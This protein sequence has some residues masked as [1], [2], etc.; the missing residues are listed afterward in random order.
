MKKLFT[1]ALL[2]AASV[3]YSQELTWGPNEFLQEVKQTPPITS[4]IVNTAYGNQGLYNIPSSTPVYVHIGVITN[5]STTATDWQ[6]VPE[7]CVWGT[8]SIEALCSSLGNNEWEYTISGS[9]ENF[10]HVDTADGEY[11]Q[12]IAIL[13]RS[14]T[15]DS[16]Q[17]NADGSDMYIPVYGDSLYSRIDVPIEQPE[18]VPIP[19]PIKATL[20]SVIPIVARASETASTDTLRVYFNGT[21]L[22]TVSGASAAKDSTSA[23]ITAYG[24]QQIVSRASNGVYANSDTVNFY[25]AEPTII[26]PLPPLTG[27]TDG[28]HYYTSPDSVTLVL[29]APYKNHIVVVGD[30]TNWIATPEYQ[31]YETPDLTRY[32]ITI[33]GLASGTQ[34]AYQYLIDDTIQVA[35]YNTELVLDKEVDP[36]IPAATY[37]NLKTFPYQAS[38]TLVSVLETGQTTYVWQVPNFT[39]PNKA[40]LIVYEMLMRDFTAAENWQTVQDTLTYLKRLGINAIE[41]MPFCNFE[42]YSSWGYNPNFYFAPDKVYGTETALKQFVDACHE[43]GI[44]VIMDLTMDDVFGSSPLAQM[45]Y[46]S[47]ANIP[48]ANN[49]WLNQYYTHAFADGFQFNHDSPATISLRKRVYKHWINDYHLDGFRFDLAGGY[50][51][52]NTCTN[53][54]NCNVAN[55]NDYD[56]DR[57]NALDSV[58]A[59]MKAISPTAYSIFEIFVN[60]PEEQIYVNTNKD[61]VWSV[62]DEN[63]PFT[64]ST[65]GFPTSNGDFSA[66]LWSSN[67][68]EPGV[69]DYEESHDETIGGDERV[70][71]KN[72]TYGNSS[73]SYNVK[74][75]TAIALER[76][77]AAA[78]FWAMMPGPKMMWM[79]EELGYDFS[80]D[81]CS[82]GTLTCGN[83]DPKPLPWGAPLNLD[84]NTQP[85]RVALF[86]VYSK[87]LHLR[88]VPNYINTFTSNVAST[89]NHDFSSYIKWMSVYSDS[90]QVMVLANFDVNQQTGTVSFPS[91]GTW[92]NFFTGADTTITSTSLSNVTLA[93]GQ[94]AVYVNVKAAIELPV[95]WLTFTATEGANNTALLNWT[96]AHEV[97]NNYFEVERS[98]PAS[99]TFKAIGDVPAANPG[100]ATNKYQFTDLHPLTGLNYYRLKQVDKDGNYSYSPIATVTIKGTDGL[101]KVYP[102]PASGNSTSLYTQS[103]FSDFTM[104]L[105][106]VS[107]KVLYNYS[108]NSL[109]EGSSVAIPTSGLAH[110][111]YF[112]KITSDQAAGTEKIMVY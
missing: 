13:F 66:A 57:V 99:T 36:Q 109:P 103:T 100:A 55:W 79:F 23:T 54:T 35:D 31:M 37:P 85:N 112:L 82:N 27:D 48:A 111:V 39:R 97:D 95:T 77:G 12:K 62:G 52:T 70:M 88:N 56:Q 65:M 43:Q 84:Y 110:G 87:L 53:G 38:G 86:N 92:Y 3:T 78:A 9:L 73:G 67:F 42:G 41:V 102:N 10:F 61:L 20:G 60:I 101:W 49:P 107:G 91:T 98:S 46:N 106:D 14:V 51:Q 24:A 81:A 1:I 6:H 4:I 22:S 28:I 108:V 29:Y 50:T 72:E 90:L 93:P 18:Y 5:F 69:V 47:S 7:F 64:Q 74:T 58:D 80:P 71:F 96:T 30:F 104:S 21:L 89:I 19:V 33:K 11:I 44:A 45:Y 2:F 63:G 105:T 17:R 26:K 34:Y 15:G 94:Y 59:E 16:A 8:D 32:W 40:N 75:D 68:S 25:V 83:T 76:T